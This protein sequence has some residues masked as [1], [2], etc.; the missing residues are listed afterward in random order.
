MGKTKVVTNTNIVVCNKHDE[1]V[2]NITAKDF[3]IQNSDCSQSV[4]LG[5]VFLSDPIGYATFWRGAYCV[6]ESLSHIDGEGNSYCKGKKHEVHY[7][8][9]WFPGIAHSEKFHIHRYK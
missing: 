8:C 1:A 2:E 9:S 7:N 5:L 4:K 3:A 6:Q